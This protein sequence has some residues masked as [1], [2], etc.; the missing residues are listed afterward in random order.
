MPV[1]LRKL[2]KNVFKRKIKEAL[3]EVLKSKDYYIVLPEIVHK[4]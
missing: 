2:S 4:S 3:F 1:S